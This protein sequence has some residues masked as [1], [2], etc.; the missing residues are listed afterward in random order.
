M[1]IEE[2]NYRLLKE[3]LNIDLNMLNFRD[4]MIVE[5]SSKGEPTV[6]IG[7]R[8]IHSRHD[9]SGEARK[10]IASAM[11]EGFDCWVF[12]G[13]GL[14]YHLETF[15]ELN[16][17]AK[18]VIVEPELSFLSAA[19]KNRSLEKI[20]SSDRVYFV[21]GPE[22]DAVSPCL[23]SLQCERIKY[24]QIRSEYELSPD[25]FEESKKAVARYV[26][27]KEINNNTL[28]RFGKIWVKNL[29]DNLAEFTVSP[30]LVHLKDLFKS[31]PSLIL[32]GGPGLDSVLPFLGELRKK[33]LLIAVDTSYRAC[34]SFGVI[35]DILIVVDPQY[36]NS[37]HLDRCGS[38]GTVLVSEPSTYSRIFRNFGNYKFFAG[39]VF[40]LGRYFEGTTFERGKIGAGGSVST[41]AW[42]LARQAG[43]SEA[44]FAGL[45]LGYPDKRTHFKGS[46]FEERAHTLSSRLRPASEMDFSLITDASLIETESSSGGVVFTDRRLI[47]YRQWFEEQFLIHDFRTLNLSLNGVLIKGMKTATL[48]DALDKPDIRD[49]IDGRLEKLKAFSESYR[50]SRGSGY[51]DETLK[52]IRELLESFKTLKNSALKGKKAARTLLFRFGNS[53]GFKDRQKKEIQKL[54]TA[55]DEADMEVLAGSGKSM[56][57]FLLQDVIRTITGDAGSKDF[58]SVIGKSL[59]I[60]TELEQSSDIHISN[61]KNSLK[62]LEKKKSRQ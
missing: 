7:N 31:I 43:C 15:L 53:I 57:G 51:I 13:L 37:R 25:F 49:E 40:P 54:F 17:E 6:R 48:R 14:G 29:C 1:E 19:A 59:K 9:P 61:L 18:A 2:K 22:P 35:P 36:W 12:G 33:Y 28:K 46:F 21:L 24:F 42:D 56:A 52:N 23:N 27:R 62:A 50:A 20:I 44:L 47:I 30:G 41:S 4:D 39:S 8:Y 11:E 38:K 10:I 55:L 58:G 5:R 16:K 26:S 60:Y 45:D 34:F 32:A 3:K